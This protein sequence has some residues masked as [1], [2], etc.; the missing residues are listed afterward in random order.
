MTNMKKLKLYEVLEN[1]FMRFLFWYSFCVIAASSFMFFMIFLAAY[2]NGGV[3]TFSINYFGE[4]NLELFLLISGL[5][6]AVFFFALI[7]K[8]LKRHNWGV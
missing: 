1:K 6:L 5:P 4:G 2:L 7:R 8:E 3:T